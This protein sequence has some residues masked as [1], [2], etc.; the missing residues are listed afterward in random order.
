M[1]NRLAEQSS[2]L[3]EAINKVGLTLKIKGVIFILFLLVL[4]IFGWLHFLHYSHY[5]WLTI[6]TIAAWPISTFVFQALI[7]RKKT[8]SEINNS[9]FVY[10]ALFEL[11]FLTVLVFTNGG[12]MWIGAIFYLFIIIC[13]N[14]ALPK[15]QGHLISFVAFLWFG[16]AAC[17]QYLK[18][19]PFLSCFKFSE[20][21]YPSL[22]FEYLII[23]LFFVFLAFVLS[24]FSAS[25]LTDLLR[26]RTADLEKLKSQ[27]EETKVVLGIR[28]RAR[29]RELEEIAN[30]LDERVKEQT[31]ELRDSQGA[32][33]NTLD[34]TSAIIA[35]LTDGLLVFDDQGT[36][37]LMNPSA[38][39]LLQTKNNEIYNKSLETLASLFNRFKPLLEVLGKGI[40]ELTRQE[41]TFGN[42]TFEVSSL[43]ITTDQNKSNRLV[44]LHDITREK[45]IERMKTEF[46]SIAAHQ[47][48]TP[49]SAIKW[50]LSL[51]LEGDAGKLNAEQKNFISKS[52]DSNERMIVLI[53]DLLDVAR[54]EEGRYLYKLV[55]AKLENLAQAALSAC[56]E[57]AAKRNIRLEYLKPAE[58]LPEMMIDAEKIT[59]TIQNL[60]ENAIKY[61]PPGGQV[62]IS[63]KYDTNKVELSVKDTGVGINQEQQNRLFTKFF[64]AANV[65]RMETDG[66]GLGLFIAKNIIEAHGGQIWCESKENK[67]STF[68]FS[69]PINH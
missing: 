1:P 39:D 54:I 2:E 26:K 44:I 65:M 20:I 17:L 60:I 61:T 30:T 42:L 28:V 33:L 32:L 56:Q 51:L 10:S 6:A 31:K 23:T 3:K 19:I 36:L 50:A 25:A 4:L 68:S 8:V 69:L 37:S 49:L 21:F 12:V 67:G 47:L 14:I 66:T 46:V 16:G 35:H 27:L 15:T 62:T 63:L 24:G 22:T 52:Y 13:A 48:R 18:I 38:I 40:K 34:K 53:N 55:P 57:I 11:G 43:V 64:R 9:H 5:T 59:I 58:A 45:G 29:T 41:I 7:K